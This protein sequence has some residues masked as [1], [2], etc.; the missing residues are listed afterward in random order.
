MDT[1]ADYQSRLLVD[2]LGRHLQ[3]DMADL[4]QVECTH[5]QGDLEHL[6]DLLDMTDGT[7][8]EPGKKVETE[9][10][11]DGLGKIA[12]WDMRRYE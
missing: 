10:T 1:V 3:S 7:Q 2:E 8:A 6:D 12:E 4:S 11:A 5:H 9:K